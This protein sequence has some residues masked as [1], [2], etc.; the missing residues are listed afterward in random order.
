MSATY[1]TEN[2]LSKVQRYEKQPPPTPLLIN[3]LSQRQRSILL[4]L[5]SLWLVTLVWFWQW[6]LQPQHIV[7]I[8][9]AIVCSLLLAWNTMLPA[10]YFFF[11]WQMKRT[12]PNLELPDDWRVAIVVTKA[13][14]EPWDM[15]EKTL[16]AMIAQDYPH[17]NWLADENPSPETLEWCRQHDIQ[18]STRY[19]IEAYHQPTW[20]RRTKCKEGNLAYFYDYYGYEKYDFVAQLDADHVPEPGYL[21]AMLRPFLNDRVG[22]VAAPSICDANADR[23]WVV[24][25]RLFA[26]ATMHGSLQAGYSNGWAPLCIGSHY[27]VRTRAVK[28]IGGLGPELAEDHTTTLMM[29]SFGW[30]GV[31][32]L[33]A[34][35]HGDGPTSFADFL[36]QEFQWAR[37]LVVVLLSITPRYI[38][39]LPPHLKFQFLFSQ[40]WYPIFAL[41]MLIGSLMPTVALVFDRP[42]MSVD[43]LEFLG[44][45]FI[46][47]MTCVFPVMLVKQ[48]GALRPYD[49]KI[50][51]WETVLFQFA[52]WPWILM[53]V[54]NATVSCVRGQ[55]LPFKVTPKGQSNAKPLPFPLIV[56]YLILALISGAAVLFCRDVDRAQGYYFLACLNMLIYTGLCLLVLQLHF[57]ENVLKYRDYLPHYGST[58][59]TFGLLV[60]ACVMQLDKG[61][62]AMVGYNPLL[63][64]LL[65]QPQSKSITKVAMKS[66]ATKFVSQNETLPWANAREGSKP[67][68]MSG[69]GPPL[70]D[71]AQQVPSPFH[72]GT[73]P[74][75]A[76]LPP[77][78]LA[79]LDRIIA[80]TPEGD[81]M[82]CQRTQSTPLPN[83]PPSILPVH[84]E[85]QAVPPN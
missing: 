12:N 54:W 29:N 79:G 20:P 33:D 52:R 75:Q 82:V 16:L 74:L 83:P 60:T 65:N 85:C 44:R 22:Y 70:K 5:V 59:L 35:A 45:S 1:V 66:N 8:G 28:D 78:P 13:P 51:S 50:I 7:T 46:L 76:L 67:R 6:W 2:E 42:W 23:S 10:Y 31:F 84:L 24:N 48:A 17:D 9:G 39:T 40:C 21:K 18:V 43:Y 73:N 25:A 11:V 56:P 68:P 63:K 64:S 47:T 61:V 57:R 30:R 14:S 55:E 38:G 71:R 34:E 3:V 41:T 27:A 26:E 80:T 15:V 4:G 62:K 53:A 36:V 49:A 69:N 37:S 81:V 58:G 32:A 72:R 77:E 19:G